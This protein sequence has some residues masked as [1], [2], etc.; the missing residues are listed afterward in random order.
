MDDATSTNKNRY[1]VG[2]ALEM[3]QHGMLDTIRTPF[4]ITGHT[5]FARDRVF[6]SVAN[7]YNKSDV[8]NCQ[9]LIDIGSRYA[10]ATEETGVHILQE[11]DKKYTLLSGIRK[12]H[13]FFVN[14]DSCDESKGTV[15]IR[16][17][18]N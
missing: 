12:Y 3:V 17:L 2:W 18:S 5:K 8:F 10:T 4:L 6:A 13:D 9:E 14:R 16:R 15:W 7:S 1:L 11:L